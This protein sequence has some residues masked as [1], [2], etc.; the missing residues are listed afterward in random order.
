MKYLFIAGLSLALGGLL[1]AQN[2]YHRLTSLNKSE[3]WLRSS[4]AAMVVEPGSPLLIYQYGGALINLS[5]DN[6]GQVS[7]LRGTGHYDLNRVVRTGDDTIFLAFPVKH[8]YQLQQ[9]QLVVAPAGSVQNIDTERSATNYNGAT[10]G[11]LFLAAS[12]ELSISA[13][14]LAAGAGFRGGAGRQANSDC[15]RFTAAN[16]ETYSLTNWRGAPRGEGVSPLP[17]GQESGRAPVA[18][19]G[20]GGNDHNSGGG[21]GANVA[22]GGGGAGNIVRG[23]LNNSCRGNFPGR[24]GRGLLV[25]DERLYFGGGG[26]AG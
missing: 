18:N 23:L 22:A 19:G 12:S 24:P 9:T 17:S 10:G 21:G 6:I 11:I 4:S 16:N 3:G 13:P 2:T 26:G 20:G 7:D 1:S 25:D 5:G 14:L 8:T 15:N